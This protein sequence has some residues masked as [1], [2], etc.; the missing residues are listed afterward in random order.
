MAKRRKEGNPEWHNSQMTARYSNGNQKEP[1]YLKIRVVNV[2]KQFVG[3]VLIPFYD[4]LR[5]NVG[6]KMILDGI[7]LNNEKGTPTNGKIDAEIIFFIDGRAAIAK[8]TA[9]EEKQI[10]KNKQDFLDGKD[11]EIPPETIQRKEDANKLMRLR[12]MFYKIDKDGSHTITT[13]ELKII[14]METAESNKDISRSFCKKL[15]KRIK[16]NKIMQI[17]LTP[18]CQK[19]VKTIP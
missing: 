4:I 19:L 7:T 1:D 17:N 8:T 5:N 11:V 3:E 16:R 12:E 2:P 13:D 10:V 9:K 18:I 6:G 15:G 14:L